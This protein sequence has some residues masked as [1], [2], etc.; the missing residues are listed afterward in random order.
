M[1]TEGEQQVK[2]LSSD[3][4]ELKCGKA[5]YHINHQHTLD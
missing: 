4:I 5:P 3:G 2:L 1:A